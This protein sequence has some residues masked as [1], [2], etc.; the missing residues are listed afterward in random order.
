MAQMNRI[1]PNDRDLMTND[2]KTATAKVL[3]A[4]LE[5][6]P[7]LPPRYSLTVSIRY[8]SSGSCVGLK[9]AK[10]GLQKPED[11]WSAITM[12]R[13]NARITN[14]DSF[15]L[16]FLKMT[17]NKAMAMGI[18]VVVFV[19]IHMN[20]SQKSESLPLSLRSNS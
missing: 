11:I 15:I 13:A 12:T 4:W 10:N 9:R 16:L 3:A 18:Q 7:Y 20:P 17:Y 2:K 1:N 19:A 14:K 5:M 8:M 6:K